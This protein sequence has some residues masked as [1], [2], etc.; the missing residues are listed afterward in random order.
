MT[1]LATVRIHSL[2]VESLHSQESRLYTAIMSSSLS[3]S[4]SSVKCAPSKNLNTSFP[5]FPTAHELYAHLRSITQPG[6]EFVVRN[7][8][9]VVEDISPD[10]S[11]VYVDVHACRFSACLQKYLCATFHVGT[12]T[13][14]FCLSF[15]FFAS[16]VLAVK[17]SSSPR[18]LYF[19]T[20]KRTWDG[21]TR[22]RKQKCGN[23]L[24]EVVNKE[25][26]EKE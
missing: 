26:I 4:S 12:H 8:V 19:T 18:A 14:D 3:S 11:L 9:A 1:R 13:D 5:H 21:N 20:R 10:A 6:G 22:T 7:F 16:S 25:I 24:N 2:A 15:S 23:S 17:R